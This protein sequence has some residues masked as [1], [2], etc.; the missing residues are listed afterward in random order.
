MTGTSL[1]AAPAI[2]P[3]LDEAARRFAAKRRRSLYVGALVFTGLAA[4]PYLIRDVYLQNVLVLTLL[5]A[6]LS[7]S[8]NILGG[9]CGQ[10]SL[11]HALYFGIGAYATSILFVN[12]GVSPWLGLLPSRRPLLLDRHHRHRR[13][14]AAARAELGLRRRGDGRAMAVQPG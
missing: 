1:I 12:Y 9:Y 10:V 8:W 13:S 14:R 5:Y 4:L 7:Q 6:A 3:S 11:G 2:S